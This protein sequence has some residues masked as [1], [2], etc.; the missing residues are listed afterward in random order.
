MSHPPLPTDFTSCTYKH[1]YL[2]N[3]K[4]FIALQ[5]TIPGSYK[6]KEQSQKHRNLGTCKHKLPEECLTSLKIADGELFIK[7]LLF[8]GHV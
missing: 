4:Y 1:F 8:A 7:N 6:Y 5:I 2:N 3:Q